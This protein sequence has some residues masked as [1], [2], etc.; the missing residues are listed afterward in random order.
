VGRTG[1]GPGCPCRRPGRRTQRA[2]SPAPRRPARAGRRSRHPADRTA[3][4]PARP[5]RRWQRRAG[6]CPL[7]AVA[8]GVL[9][10]PLQNLPHRVRLCSAQGLPRWAVEYHKLDPDLKR[11]V[12]GDSRFPAGSTRPTLRSRVFVV[13]AGQTQCIRIMRVG[14]VGGVGGWPAGTRRT[15]ATSG[16][17]FAVLL[18]GSGVPAHGHAPTD[19]AVGRGRPRSASATCLPRRLAAPT[20]ASPPHH[21]RKT[22]AC[23]GNGAA[24][25]GYPRWRAGSFGRLMI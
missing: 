24:A 13:S 2:P 11:C 19:A 9:G 23:Y 14:G 15:A 6:S 20:R 21:A 12:I 17:A 18:V 8:V 10:D 16:R 25:A 7:A 1:W 4:P 22:G 3:R 5:R